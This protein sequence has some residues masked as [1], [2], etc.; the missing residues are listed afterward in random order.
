MLEKRVAEKGMLWRKECCGGRSVG[1]E[2]PRGRSLQ[3]LAEAVELTLRWKRCWSGCV[4]ESTSFGIK[5][6]LRTQNRSLLL[7]CIRVVGCAVFIFWILLV[8]C[9]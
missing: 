5:K 4:F 9:C 1:E 3:R 6:M 7:I 2:C 8:I